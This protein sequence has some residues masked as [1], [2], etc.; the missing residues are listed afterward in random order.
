[1]AMMEGSP[2]SQFRRSRHYLF[3]DTSKVL[4]ALK[5]LQSFTFRRAVQ[6]TD[7]WFTE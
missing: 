5:L 1:M 4:R 3:R 7:D 2:L 6:D